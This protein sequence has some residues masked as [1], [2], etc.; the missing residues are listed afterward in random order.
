MRS[1][2]R[3]WYV[4]Y[5]NA[6]AIKDKSIIT[7]DPYKGWTLELE[8]KAWRDQCEGMFRATNGAN[9]LSESFPFKVKDHY[10]ARFEYALYHIE[11][12]IA[13]AR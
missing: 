8:V 13:E 7:L 3:K 2:D 4:S 5:E 10:S 6:L 12:K 1:M 11:R 9:T